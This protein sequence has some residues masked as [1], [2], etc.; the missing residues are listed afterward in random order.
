MFHLES[1]LE[2]NLQVLFKNEF[3]EE[4]AAQEEISLLK[5]KVNLRINLADMR[6]KLIQQFGKDFFQKRGKEIK[7]LMKTRNEM[8]LFS[9]IKF[10]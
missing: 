5:M 6:Q 8:K 3:Q 2:V 4:N 1:K 7:N 10:A 9:L